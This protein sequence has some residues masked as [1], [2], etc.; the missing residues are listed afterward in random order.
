MSI[1][2]VVLKPV[3]TKVATSPMTVMPS[4]GS[5]APLRA[6]LL[7]GSSDVRTVPGTIT[8][9]AT[10]VVPRPGLPK[11]AVATTTAMDLM[12]DTPPLVL[13][14]ALPPGNSK[15]LPLV[16]SL[17]LLR[18]LRFPVTDTE[19]MQVMLILL[20]WQHRRHLLVCLLW[21][22]IAAPAVR[23]LPRLLVMDLLLPLPVTSPHPR[24]RLRE[25]LSSSVDQV[26]TRRVG[27]TVHYLLLEISG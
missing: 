18:L 5:V 6:M 20:A 24:L 13:Q 21:V 10:K 11:T 1:R 26:H 22:A 3:P 17:P 12:V 4:R 9:L 15:P 16:L 25:Q 2:L 14:L 19:H 7:P 23:H 8:D 27:G